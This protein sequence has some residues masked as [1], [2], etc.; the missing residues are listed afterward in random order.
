M[1]D[2]AEGQYF[3]ATLRGKSVAALG[4]N[5]VEGV[6]PHWNT[7]ISVESAD[8]KFD[9]A[10]TQ[11]LLASSGGKNIEVIEDLEA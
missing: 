2:D 4:S 8:P 3:M 9:L 11:S 6:P 1:P 5:P 10:Q 7:Y